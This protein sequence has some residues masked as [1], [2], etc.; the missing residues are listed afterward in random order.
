MWLAFG[1]QNSCLAPGSVD[2]GS[3]GGDM[4][5]TALNHFAAVCPCRLGHQ[6]Q[7]MGLDSKR[8][9]STVVLKQASGR[10]QVRVMSTGVTGTPTR[11]SD[12]TRLRGQ[13]LRVLCYAIFKVRA[14]SLCPTCGFGRPLL[15]E[16]GRSGGCR[17]Y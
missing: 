11:D 14:V 4:G 6:L 3:R 9:Q 10:T 15:M 17:R 12:H 13:W 16:A 7:Q 5:V 1:D 8:C 2:S